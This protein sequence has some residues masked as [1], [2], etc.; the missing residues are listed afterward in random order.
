MHS[1]WCLGAEDKHDTIK[2][3]GHQ[4]CR[5]SFID[6]DPHVDEGGNARPRRLPD[7]IAVAEASSTPARS[8]P[9]R[10]STFARRCSGVA[11]HLDGVYD[12]RSDDHS[13]RLLSGETSLFAR[14]DPEAD[15][16]GID[17]SRA[18]V[19]RAAARIGSVDGGAPV[20][21]VTLT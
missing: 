2:A 5:E 19:P 21:P 17:S 8:S 4:G 3:P 9:T 14:V 16:S 7:V 11:P 10:R 15:H 6:R 18:S 13:I 1:R 20:T 12:G